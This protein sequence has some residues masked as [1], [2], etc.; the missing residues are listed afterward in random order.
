MSRE[1][2]RRDDYIDRWYAQACK[3][4]GIAEDHAEKKRCL[5][6]LVEKIA[7]SKFCGLEDIHLNQAEICQSFRSVIYKEAKKR[8]LEE[9][10]EM[11]MLVRSLKGRKDYQNFFLDLCSSRDLNIAMMRAE[12]RSE[13]TAKDWLERIF[14]KKIIPLKFSKFGRSKNT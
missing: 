8:I 6:L 11:K 4:F 10:R 12:I 2:F 14:G 13:K 5:I 1:D 3:D 7:T 9:K